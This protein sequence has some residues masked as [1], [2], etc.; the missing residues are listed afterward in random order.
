MRHKPLEWGGVLQKATLKGRKAGRY[1]M[2]PPTAF[3]STSGQLRESGQSEGGKSTGTGSLPYRP[4]RVGGFCRVQTTT[5]PP[6][7]IKSGLPGSLLFYN[8]VSLYIMIVLPFPQCLPE[9]FNVVP[10]KKHV[11]SKVGFW[12]SRDFL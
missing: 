6:I 10:H 3:P 7:V 12:F 4:R 11:K 9:L 1:T 5:L 2:P 8:Q